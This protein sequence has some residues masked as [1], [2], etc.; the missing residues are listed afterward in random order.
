MMQRITRYKIKAAMHCVVLKYKDVTVL[1]PLPIDN[2][3]V[4]HHFFMLVAQQS[5]QPEHIIETMHGLATRCE[6]PSQLERV[7]NPLN[8][9]GAF[10][11]VYCIR[12]VP[13]GLECGKLN[14]KQAAIDHTDDWLLPEQSEVV[15]GHFPDQDALSLWRRAHILMEVLNDQGPF[16]Y[17]FLGLGKTLGI[18]ATNSN[19]VYASLALGLDLPI[20]RFK[21][22]LAPGINKPVLSKAEIEAH[23]NT[24]NTRQ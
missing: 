11:K 17:S 7:V 23:S 21:G 22:Y 14:Y 8:S 4:A 5:G 3:R 9:W 19:S 13:K 24:L 15:Y 16:P 1:K 20:H 18:K 10:L 6:E 2:L 12:P